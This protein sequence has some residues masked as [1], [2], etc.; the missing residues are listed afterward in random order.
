MRFWFG[1]GNCTRSANLI[2]MPLK[3]SWSPFPEG[4]TGLREIYIGPITL[5]FWS[6]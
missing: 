5:Q 2:I 3:W 4:V 1:I 6:K